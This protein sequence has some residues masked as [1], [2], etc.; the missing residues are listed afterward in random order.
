VVGMVIGGGAWV[1]PHG[2]KSGI[3]ATHIQNI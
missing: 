3:F 1:K 2:Q